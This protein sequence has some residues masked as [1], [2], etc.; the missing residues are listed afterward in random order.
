MGSILVGLSDNPGKTRDG[1]FSRLK[2][3]LEKSSQKL[4]GSIADLFTKGRL[5]SAILEEIQQNKMEEV[6]QNLKEAKARKYNKF[7]N[8]EI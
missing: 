6:R 8:S 4:S 7:T 3:G 5:D 1:W 2:N